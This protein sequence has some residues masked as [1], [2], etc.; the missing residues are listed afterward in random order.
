MNT[1]FKLQQI[2]FT[3]YFSAVTLSN[4][5]FKRTLKLTLN[6]HVFDTLANEWNLEPMEDDGEQE[7]CSQLLS[8]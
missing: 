7:L 8:S 2:I 4:L 6:V 3:K 1:V 5:N